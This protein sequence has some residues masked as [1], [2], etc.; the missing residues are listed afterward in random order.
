MIDKPCKHIDK[1][2]LRFPEQRLPWLL[3]QSQTPSL[4]K[5]VCDSKIYLSASRGLAVLTRQW[6]RKPENHGRLPETAEHTLQ[7]AFYGTGESAEPWFDV[8]R[9]AGEPKLSHP[10]WHARAVVEKRCASGSSWRLK[11]WNNFALP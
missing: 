2:M 5:R 9:Y 7:H 1:W 8:T 6:R 10:R 11:V 4:R 3:G